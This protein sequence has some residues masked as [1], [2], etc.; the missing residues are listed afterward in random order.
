MSH[1]LGILAYGS[2]IDD[3]GPELAPVIRDRILARTPFRVEFARSSKKRGGGPTLIPVEEGGSSVDGRVL[4]LADSVMVSEAFD[5]LWRR[6]TGSGGVY[7][8]SES[9][10]RNTV[11][12]DRLSH[13][14]GVETVLYTQIGSNI[15]DLSPALLAELAIESAR[16][17]AGADRKDGIS[18]LLDAKSAGIRTPMSSDYEQAILDRLGIDDL[19]QAVDASRR[20]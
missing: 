10:T 2:L 9:P 4:V 3:P 18:Y 17:Q 12:V 15:P 13:F 19:D 16:S 1:H 20:V 11:I 8:V 14:E 6:E 5:M 7:K